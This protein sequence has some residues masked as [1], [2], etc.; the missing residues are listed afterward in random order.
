MYSEAIDVLKNSYTLYMELSKQEFARQGDLALIEYNLSICY[1][2]LNEY[3]KAE[4]YAI[5]CC[6]AYK[7]MISAEKSTTIIYLQQYGNAMTSLCSIYFKNKKFGKAAWCF[8]K[9]VNSIWWSAVKA[10]L[11]G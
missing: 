5:K 3:H 8:V 11:F 4:E 10:I 9:M 6:G 1:H 2:H 7:E